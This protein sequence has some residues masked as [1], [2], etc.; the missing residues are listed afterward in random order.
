MNRTDTLVS[1]LIVTYMYMFLKLSDNKKSHFQH[2]LFLHFNSAETHLPLIQPP[3]A[4]A[5]PTIVCPIPMPTNFSVGTVRI[6]PV[7]HKIPPVKVND[8][9]GGC[10]QT[11]IFTINPTRSAPVAIIH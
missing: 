3:I 1:K 7:P 8:K 2:H 4:F 5:T 11:D 10:F 9:N 6:F